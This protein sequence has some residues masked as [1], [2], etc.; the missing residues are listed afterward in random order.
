MLSRRYGPLNFF[1][2]FAL[3]VLWLAVCP[4]TAFASSGMIFGLSFESLVLSVLG[5]RSRMIQFSCVIV[6][7]GIALLYWK[8]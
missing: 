4:K 6:G 5:D 7:I 1:A 3:A 2:L 8:K